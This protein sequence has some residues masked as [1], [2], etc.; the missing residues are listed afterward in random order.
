MHTRFVTD[1]D[2]ELG[3]RQCGIDDSSIRERA[4]IGGRNHHSALESRP[5]RIE[6]ALVLL[7]RQ[8]RD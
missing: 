6:I 2:F 7:E 3:V 8:R 1:N 5:E 4:H